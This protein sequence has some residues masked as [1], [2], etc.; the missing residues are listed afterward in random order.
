MLTMTWMAWFNGPGPARFNR[1]RHDA[2]QTI[3]GFSPR[4]RDEVDLDSLTGELLAVV[5]DTM[6][7]TRRRCGYGPR[8]GPA[9]PAG[10]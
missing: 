5:E 1:R 4:L 2:A 7:P 10:P 9:P 6:Q 8:D 3:E